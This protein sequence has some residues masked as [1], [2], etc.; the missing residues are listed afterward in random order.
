MRSRKNEMT[1]P[2]SRRQTGAKL[3]LNSR[4]ADSP[5]N[6]GPPQSV[7]PTHNIYS[8]YAPKSPLT[9]HESSL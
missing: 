5:S 9:M 4:A 3:W 8:Y 2:R 7:P 6:D 1:C